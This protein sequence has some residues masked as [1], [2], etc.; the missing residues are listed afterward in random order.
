MKEYTYFDKNH[1][2]DVIIKVGQ[3]AEENWDLLKKSSQ[4]DIWIH[5]DNHPSPHVFIEVSSKKGISKD[6]I[7][8]GA[9]LCKMHSKLKTVS[10]KVPIIYADVK[11]V[12]KGKEVGSVIVKK[13]NKISV[14]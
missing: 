5:L 12:K 13:S 6:T 1:N 2:K 4:R 9:T 7:R 10:Q 14:K 3:T 11:D 8:Y